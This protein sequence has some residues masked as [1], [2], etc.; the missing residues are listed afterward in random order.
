VIHNA[1]F[2]L[3]EELSNLLPY[4]TKL[5]S[6]HVDARFEIDVIASE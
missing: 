3:Q 1:P 5:L 2:G 6:I 4:L